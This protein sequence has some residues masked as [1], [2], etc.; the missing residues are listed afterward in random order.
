[1]ICVKRPMASDDRIRI[2]EPSYRFRQPVR[3]IPK[4]VLGNFCALEYCGPCRPAA[5]KL[6]RMALALSFFALMFALGLEVAACDHLF[7]M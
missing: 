7:K 6:P 3:S 4:H 2:P 1:M 5:T